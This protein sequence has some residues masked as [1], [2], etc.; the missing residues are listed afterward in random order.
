MFWK[1]RKRKA[2]EAGA[3]PGE[4]EAFDAT[5]TVKLTNKFGLHM[6]PAGEVVKLANSFPCEIEVA[7]G[8]TRADAKRLMAL[9][10]LQAVGGSELQVNA[11]GERAAEAV[12]ALAKLLA[13]LPEFD[14]EQMARQ[15]KATGRRRDGAK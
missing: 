12:A 13:S 14:R 15:R 11:R 8:K 6:R 9:I 10:A 5:A 4:G 3:P 1:R 7:R 2:A